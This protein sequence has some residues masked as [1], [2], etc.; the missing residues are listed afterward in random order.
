[1]V[2]RRSWY[3]PSGFSECRLTVFALALALS[4]ALILLLGLSS[5]HRHG[6]GQILYVS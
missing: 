6:L 2:F 5:R 4:V 3:F 1:M